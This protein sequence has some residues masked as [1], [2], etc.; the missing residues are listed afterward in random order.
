MK[1]AYKRTSSGKYDLRGLKF[2]RWLVLDEVLEERNRKWLCRCDCGTE[3]YVLERS[4]VYGGSQSCGCL[5]RE[6]AVKSNSHDLIGQ[7][8][9]ELT[10]LKRSSKKNKDG[11]I[12][13]LCRCSC[14][15]ELEVSGTLLY[16]GRKTSCGCKAEHHYASADIAGKKFNRLTA[17]HPTEK[18]TSRGSVIWHCKCECGNEVDVSYNSLAYGNMM[19]CGCQKKEND[20]KL[21]DLLAFVDGTSVDLIRSKK[22][23][24]NNTTGVKGVYFI[25]NKYVAKIVFQHKAYYLGT[26]DNIEEAAAARKCAEETICDS[27]VDFYDKWKALAEKNPQWA[28]ENPI[29]F[30]V[31]K[32]NDN[33]QIQM[34]PDL[35]GADE[36]KK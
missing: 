21:Q 23:S 34:L 35:N 16:C 15:K 29:K 30:M 4:L 36:E 2:G 8:F 31:S 5:A 24:K 18:R 19:S 28:K 27:A 1:C 12:H 3:R 20:G 7:Q 13:W 14:G 17:L 33:L 26:Y 6:R 9:G 11:N 32:I 10:V 25:R 22:I